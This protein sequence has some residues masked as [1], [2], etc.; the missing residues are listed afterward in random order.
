MA[1]TYRFGFKRLEVYQ[2]AVDHFAWTVAVVRREPRLPYKV[3]AQ[4]L[5]SSLSVLSNIGEA[6][7]REKQPG[8]AEQHV[9]YAQGSTAECASHLDALAALDLIDDDEYNAREAHLAR[10]AAMLQGLHRRYRGRRS[11]PTQEGPQQEVTP[12]G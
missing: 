5:G 7:G 9:R 1:K 11:A 4:V 2:A 3:S 10:I 8:E 6:T 12:S